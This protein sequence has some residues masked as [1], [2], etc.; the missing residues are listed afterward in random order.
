MR[1][2]LSPGSA[3]RVTRDRRTAAGESARVHPANAAR[4]VKI[5]ERFEAGRVVLRPVMAIAR[6]KRAPAQP[7]VAPVAEPLPVT[8]VIPVAISAVVT[9]SPSEES[10]MM[11]SPSPGDHRAD[12][13]DDRR[14]TP[15]VAYVGPPPVVIRRPAPR[16]IRYPRPSVRR[17]P[18]PI[19]VA[20]RR[21]VG[22]DSAR[23]PH[24]AVFRRIDPIAVIVQ[25]V[26]ARNRDRYVTRA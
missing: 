16:L 13:D 10:H 11:R 20:I 9:A 17:K 5:P 24:P 1:D 3:Q 7:S 23:T 6:P 26:N 8:V 14:P 18:S 22:G 2:Q 19:T 25:V 12:I 15:S 21:P 4:R